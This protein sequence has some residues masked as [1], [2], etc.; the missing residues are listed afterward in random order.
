MTLSNDR[1]IE[2]DSLEAQK[3]F[4]LEEKLQVAR[5]KKKVGEV[6]VRKQVETRMVRLPIRREKL[7]VEKLGENPE[8]LAEVVINEETFNGLKYDELNNSQDLD[9]NQS[10]FISLATAKELLATLTQLSPNAQI[11]VRLDIATNGSEDKSL[12][13]KI[14]DICDR[15]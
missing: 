15:Y 14:K 3:I 4:L 8:K 13:L 6:I 5:R 7:I 12:G 10:K 9:L 1:E 2:A 11:K